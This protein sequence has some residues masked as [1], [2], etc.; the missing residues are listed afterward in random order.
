MINTEFRAP[1]DFPE[2][3]IKKTIHAPR[4]LVFKTV[5]DPIRIPDWW[6]QGRLKTKVIDMTAM[7]GGKWRFIQSDE[8]G[9]GYGFHGVYLDVVD[10]SRLVYT[11][12]FDDLPGHVMLYTD[13]FEEQQGKTIIHSIVNFPTVEDRHQ[14]MAWGM[15]NATNSMTY[16]LNWLLEKQLMHARRGK[17]VAGQ[18][19]STGCITITRLFDVPSE[20]VWQ[21]WTNPGEYMCWW[22]PK[23]YS[24]PYARFDLRVGGKH[25]ST[26][27]SPDGKDVWSI[28]K[29]K[30]IAE[31]SRIVMT[32]SFTD[33]Q[34][35]VV[36]PTYYGMDYDLPVEMELDVTLENIAG[37][38]R[39]ILKQCGV[40]E[41]AFM[42]QRR[43]DWN[44]SFDKLAGCLS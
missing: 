41:G 17:L 18:A 24:A 42:E 33:E 22:G 3:Y 43:E 37:K 10:P 25:L 39:L 15:E 7:R 35:V 20:R 13:T 34:G 44:Q 19:D 11:S 5:I 30:E 12:E 28:G 2:V 16:R 40:P 21:R 38:T 1:P 32:D 8:Q 26:M 14:M 23:D 31:P 4:D 29:Y 36:P 27:R 9:K 6:G